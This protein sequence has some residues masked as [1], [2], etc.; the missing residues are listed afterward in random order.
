MQGLVVPVEFHGDRIQTWQ[1][2]DGKI[3]VLV[4]LVCRNLGIDPASQRVKL[5][6]SPLFQ[7]HLKTSVNPS[8][9]RRGRE[10]LSLDNDYLPA[11]LASISGLAGLYSRPHQGAVPCRGSSLSIFMVIVSRVGRMMLG[12]C[13]SSSPRSA[14]ILG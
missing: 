10:P 6:R 13:M 3:Y 9:H 1:D 8:F 11:W 12:M 5:R 7:R 4:A 14:E 2:E